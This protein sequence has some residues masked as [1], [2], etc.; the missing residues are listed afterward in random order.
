MPHAL[1]LFLKT[2][3][4]TAAAATAAVFLVYLGWVAI[5]RPDAPQERAVSS[6]LLVVYSA[7]A[8]VLGFRL[9]AARGAFDP[10]VRRAWL[11]LGLSALCNAAAEAVWFGLE[12]LL[13]Q[14]PF[15]STAD[16]FYLAYYPLRLAGIMALPFVAPRRSERPTLWL[17]LGIVFAAGFIGLW[18]FLAA[19]S[20][21][22]GGVDAAALVAIAYPV[23]DLI[24]VAGLVVLAERDIERVRLG[25]VILLALNIV[26]VALADT[27]FAFLETRSLPS[28]TATLNAIWVA[29]GLCD[30]LAVAW[31]LT[32][33][34]HPPLGSPRPVPPAR[35]LLRLTLPY[36]A[37]L[38][39]L[40]VLVVA[41]LSDPPQPR[42]FLVGTLLGS[43]VLMALAMLRQFVVLRENVL[44]QEETSRLATI[45]SLT[46]LSNR[47]TLDEALEKEV[48]RAL[49]YAHPL[50]VLMLDVDGF[51]AFNDR[52]GHLQGDA[53]LHRI[54]ACLRTQVRSTD[55]LARFGG[56]EFVLILP[57]TTWEGA[58]AVGAKMRDSTCELQFA[59][60]P[61]GLSIGVAEYRPGMTPR[62]LLDE[63]D[64]SLYR[65][66]RGIRQLPLTASDPRAPASPDSL[67]SG[68]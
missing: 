15:P 66:K 27:T 56:D 55:L 34:Q 36:V 52:H 5:G 22:A 26:L 16:L 7:L 51:K 3:M 13:H 40:A 8:A 68:G 25:A 30:F 17:D 48:E 18:Y 24:A 11:F 42:A 2:R 62:D 49:R 21:V 14:D 65:D 37:T 60:S 45:D 23:A 63:V 6:I 43:L 4:G 32:L 19:P 44:L 20:W 54:C 38:L 35:R 31:M 64:Q 9:A 41:G 10:R 47:R 46:G 59:G 61:L 50:T 39:G 33:G 29:G 57:E 12:T 53:A 28:V 58:V 67:S 1:R